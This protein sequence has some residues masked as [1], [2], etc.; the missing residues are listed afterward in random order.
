M[1]MQSTRREI[2]SLFKKRGEVTVKELSQALGITSMGVRQ[3]LA[4]L[5]RDGFVTQLSIRRGRGRPGRTFALTPAGDDLFPRTYQQMA[6]AI[7]DDLRRT[8]GDGRVEQVFQRRKARLLEEYRARMAGKSLPQQVSELARIRDD[9]GYLADSES[10]RVLVLNEYNCP[11]KGIAS[12]FPYACAYEK[13][14]FEEALGVGVSRV[15]HILSGAHRCR[16]LIERAAQQTGA[17]RSR[18]ATTA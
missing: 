10:G 11:I 13:Q 15:E 16:Y 6:L 18:R 12:A 4:T 3:H 17:R 8:E 1:Q 5:E 14:L 9:E 7:L 2:L